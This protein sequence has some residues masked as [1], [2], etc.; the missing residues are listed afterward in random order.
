MNNKSISVIKEETCKYPI[1]NKI[2]SLITFSV[3]ILK[4]FKNF[5]F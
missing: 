1:I 3:I 2:L 4:T 5:K